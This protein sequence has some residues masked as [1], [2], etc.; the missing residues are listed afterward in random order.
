[1]AAQNKKLKDILKYTL[2]FLLAGVLVYFAFRKV[3]WGDFWNGLLQTRWFWVAVF[4][5]VSLVAVLFRAIRWRELLLPFDPDIKMIRVLDVINI[6][7]LTSVALPGVG[8]L[9]RCALVTNKK[10]EYDKSIGTMFC[11][12]LWDCI[13]LT[14][15]AIV[16]LLLGW[17]RFGSY[18]KEKILDPLAANTT[19]WL[20]LALVVIAIATFVILVFKL[21]HRHNLFGKIA[22]S[23]SRMWDGFTVFSKSRPQRSQSS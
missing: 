7:N 20:I 16:S 18:F 15:L 4:C 9:L 2:L 5:V 3:D 1:M 11:E 6:G 14:V 17:N 19:F 13:A 8:E 12:R 23:L 22:T 21:R 10:L